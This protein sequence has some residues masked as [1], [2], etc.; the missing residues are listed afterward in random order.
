M[1]F[2]LVNLRYLLV[3]LLVHL[4]DGV[5]REDVIFLL[6]LVESTVV[7]FQ[8][9]K[10]IKLDAKIVTVG[11]TKAVIIVWVIFRNLLQ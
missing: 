2:L 1:L 3:H 4:I 7:F 10:F 5:I 8:N 9:C 11:F 6:M